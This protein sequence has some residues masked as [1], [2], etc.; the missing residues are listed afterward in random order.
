MVDIAGARSTLRAAGTKRILA[1]PAKAGVKA[2]LM[3][4]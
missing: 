2:P 3:R 4:A 1:I